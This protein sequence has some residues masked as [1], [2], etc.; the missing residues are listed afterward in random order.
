MFRK[1]AVK[2]GAG[3]GGLLPQNPKIE[4]CCLM[5]FAILLLLCP[6]I[7]SHQPSTADG[8]H[9]QEFMFVLNTVDNGR[10]TRLVPHTSSS[11][12]GLSYVALRLG[13]PLMG[14]TRRAKSTPGIS[15]RY[16]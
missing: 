2:T 8:Q 12:V 3:L 10:T 7:F 13:V 14:L 4:S 1:I 6:Y 9:S 16:K 15:V 5:D 11:S